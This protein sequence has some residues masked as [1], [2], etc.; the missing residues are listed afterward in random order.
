MLFGQCEAHLWVFFQALG[1]LALLR[2]LSCSIK[3]LHHFC[4]PLVADMWLRV[5]WVDKVCGCQGVFGSV[6]QEGCSNM[7]GI[8]S[9]QFQR[10]S[11]SLL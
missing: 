7:C 2:K 4:F 10:L 1:N 6:E 9:R 3:P 8:V 5:L 11:K